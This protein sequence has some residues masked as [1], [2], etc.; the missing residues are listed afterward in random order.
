MAEQIKAAISNREPNTYLELNL[1][2][3]SIECVNGL[4]NI[5]L[6]NITPET[7]A[8]LLL[9]KHTQTQKMMDCST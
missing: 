4:I 1:L 5:Y 8:Q 3:N 9:K 6:E 2:F 7:G